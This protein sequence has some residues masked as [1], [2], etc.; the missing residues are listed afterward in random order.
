MNTAPSPRPLTIIPPISVFPPPIV[1]RYVFLLIKLMA[2]FLKL[3]VIIMFM[4][5]RKLLIVGIDPGITTAY[6]V[7]DIEGKLMKT[8]SSKNLDLNQLISEI[9]EIGKV[10]L[11]GTDKSKTPNLVYTFATKLGAKIIGPHKDLM[12]DE[13]RK[14]ISGFKTDD[15]HQAD[16]L[17]AALFAY[18]TS[19]PLLDKIE[20]YSKNCKK[21]GIK[22]RIKELVITKKISI[23]SAVGMIEYKN[24]EDKIVEKIIVE[25]KLNEDDFLKL[26]NRLKDYEAEIRLIKVH[27]NN[28][29]NRIKNLEKNK[30]NGIKSEKNDKVHDFRERRIISLENSAKSKN[31]EI[32]NIKLIIKRLN[33]KI[34]DISNFY[35]LKKLD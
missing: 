6:A 18:K 26:Y 16:A 21:Y 22:D 8:A 9:I 2:K 13:K 34:S 28:L 11:V 15:V 3:A 1:N 5:D 7:L 31:R 23:K 14:M 19:K 24:E 17:A 35:V 30:N 29:K 33:N 25:K 10:V 20:L 4:G 32:E 12:V 27:N